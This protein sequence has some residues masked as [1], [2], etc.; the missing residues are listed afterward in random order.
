M[1]SYSYKRY[2]FGFDVNRDCLDGA[3]PANGPQLDAARRDRH[4]LDNGKGNSAWRPKL[5]RP[6]KCSLRGR[7]QLKYFLENLSDGSRFDFLGPKTRKNTTQLTFCD[8]G[9]GG[10]S[11]SEKIQV[12]SYSYKRYRF[13]FDVNR[14][15]LNVAD[16]AIGPQLDTARTDRPPQLSNRLRLYPAVIRRLSL[17]PC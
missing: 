11:R 12:N 3:D 6:Y 17:I 15:W 8:F 1:N 14:D 10:Y 5:T 16:P 9:G 7:K 4:K 2:R 13:G